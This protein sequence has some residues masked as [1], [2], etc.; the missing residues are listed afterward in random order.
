MMV[1]ALPRSYLY[2]AEVWRA[3]A[4]QQLEPVAV[5]AIHKLRLNVLPTSAYARS[6]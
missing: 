1:R 5:C 2:L 6:R 4:R 3:I